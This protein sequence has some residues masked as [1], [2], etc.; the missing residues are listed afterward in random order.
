MPEMLTFYIDKTSGTFADVLL[1]FG[2]MRVLSELHYRQ[3]TPHRLALKD[4][5]LYYRVTCAPIFQETLENLRQ[6]PVWPGDTT[7]HRYDQKSG[8]YPR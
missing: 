5:G 4:D 6:Q 2:W 3:E 8:D 1:A 7:H